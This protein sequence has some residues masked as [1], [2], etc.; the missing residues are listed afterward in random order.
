MPTVL[1]INEIIMG[2]RFI[3]TKW[4]SLLEGDYADLKQLKIQLLMIL[5]FK[6]LLAHMLFFDGL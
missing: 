2:G 6:I 3:R 5:F 4:V 1:N